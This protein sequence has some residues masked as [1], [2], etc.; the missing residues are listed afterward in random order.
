TKQSLSRESNHH[1]KVRARNAFNNLTHLA[2]FDLHN[3]E[4]A[5]DVVGV[6]P[7]LRFL[8]LIGREE[9]ELEVLFGQNSRPF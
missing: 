9:E 4:L 1:G 8:A 6:A 5:V 2:M 7:N 3:I